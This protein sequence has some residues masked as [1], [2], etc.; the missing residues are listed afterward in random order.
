MN[1]D[2]PKILIVDDK[3]ENLV[4]LEKVLENLDIELIRASSGN[5]ALE[6][7]LELEFALV[8]MDV[9]MPGMDGFETV[10][11]M[12]QKEKTRHLPVIMISAIYST[13]YYK[14]KGVESGAIDFITKPIVPKILYGKVTL[15][16]ELY[17][18]NKK[19]EKTLEEIKTLQGLLPI[20]SNCKKIRNDKGCWEH[21]EVYISQRTDAEFTH[22]IC[23]DCV[24]ELYP[25]LSVDILKE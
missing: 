16:L 12:H 15:F 24:T 14:I 13:D 4:V 9:Q 25:G 21:L 11:I 18:K 3:I 8:L 20:C 17:Q 1:N 22:G 2:K 23:A 7:L 10:E 5:E 6:K 19:L